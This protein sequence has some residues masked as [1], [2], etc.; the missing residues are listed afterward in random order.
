MFEDM[1]FMCSL[2]KERRGLLIKRE[3]APD[4]PLELRLQALRGGAIDVALWVPASPH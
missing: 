1:A 3:Q 2:L 4:V